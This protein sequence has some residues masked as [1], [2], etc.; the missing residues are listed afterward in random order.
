MDFASAFGIFTRCRVQR[1]QQVVHRRIVFFI[2]IRNGCSQ[3]SKDI[4]F[5]AEFCVIGIGIHVHGERTIVVHRRCDHCCLFFFCQNVV[6]VFPERIERVHIVN[7]A[8]AGIAFGYFPQLVIRLAH[9]LMGRE[10]ERV[11]GENL[12]VF[13]NAAGKIL[14]DRQNFC[15]NQH[16]RNIGRRCRQSRIHVIQCRFKLACGKFH[17]GKPSKGLRTTFVLLYRFFQRIQ[18]YSHY[19]SNGRRIASSAKSTGIPS[20]TG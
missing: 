20:R 19:F 4:F 12:L 1:I 14:L 13:G 11:L 7:A 18:R 3:I 16:C 10:T 8:E 9:F 15:P 17:I 2:G 6:F 5:T